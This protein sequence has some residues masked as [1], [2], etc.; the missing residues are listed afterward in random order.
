MRTISTRRTTIAAALEYARSE[1][2]TLYREAGST[3]LESGDDA[4][5]ARQDRIHATMHFGPDPAA[6]HQRD[7]TLAGLQAGSLYE[8]HAHRFLT[9][10]RDAGLHLSHHAGSDES[11]TL[12]VVQGWPLGGDVDA[13]P[14]D[15]PCGQVVIATIDQVCQGRHVVSPLGPVPGGG[16]FVGHSDPRQ[17]PS[18]AG[19]RA[20]GLNGFQ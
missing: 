10:D 14:L 19:S 20:D 13:A 8:V 7:L 15:G 11:V 18:A 16:F 3:A 12:I 9:P 4:D 6:Q 1:H 2:E 17:S 5:E